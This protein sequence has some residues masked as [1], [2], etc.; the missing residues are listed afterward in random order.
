M[1]FGSVFHR[2]AAEILRTLRR[3]GESQIPTEEA[4]AIFREVYATSGIV[5]PIHGNFSYDRLRWQVLK[6]CEHSWPAGGIVAV[7]ERLTTDVACPDGKIRQVTGQPDA[8]IADPPRGLIIPDFK[9][10]MKRPPEPRDGDY[11]REDGKPFLSPQGL[12]QLHV[13]GF[14]AMTEW[15]GLDYVILREFHTRWNIMREAKLYREELEHVTWEIGDL[16]QKLDT[17]LAEGEDSELWRARPGSHCYHCPGKLDCPVPHE[18]RED[19]SIRDEGS[20]LD[21]AVLY[22]RLDSMRKHTIAALKGWLDAG[23]EAPI[24]PDGHSY[25][26]WKQVSEKTRRFDTHQIDVK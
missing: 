3:Q 22:T 13:Y 6:F 1:D 14:Q 21:H 7:E 17:A 10:G 4:M 20:A 8:I 23:N 18:A 26:G 2:V 12:F 9:R 11:S 24:L 25:V 5:L 19:G 15:K 16:L